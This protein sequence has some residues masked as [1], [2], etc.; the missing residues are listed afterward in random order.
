MSAP[1]GLRMDAQ[2]VISVAAHAGGA[3]D[4]T[5][6]ALGVVAGL[7]LLLA[8]FALV[9]GFQSS[10]KFKRFEAKFRAQT[11]N[12]EAPDMVTQPGSAHLKDDASSAP[13]QEDYQ[14]LKSLY[15]QLKQE[16]RRLEA[17]L[18]RQTEVPVQVNPA[19]APTLTPA[20][21]SAASSGAGASP[22]LDV[23][24]VRSRTRSA[25]ASLQSLYDRPFPLQAEATRNGSVFLRMNAS[26]ALVP[27]PVSGPHSD[28]WFLAVKDSVTGRYALYFG[29]RVIRERT[30]LRV[31]SDFLAS[32]EAYY[33]VRQ[34]F[35][36]LE[37]VD[38]CI[39]EIDGAGGLSTLQFGLVHA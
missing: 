23:D 29:P 2:P 12:P 21:E 37:L 24:A 28:R 20:Q 30:K 5:L 10:S 31:A 32:L 9:F 13:T 19:P 6:L 22:S 34:G 36:N 39:I 26:G 11:I 8:V 15:E 14:R 18:R 3:P 7:A 35:N 1:A 4:L 17:E 16:V 25:A 33:T 38:A 27:E